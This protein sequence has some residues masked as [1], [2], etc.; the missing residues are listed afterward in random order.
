MG[1]H[2]GAHLVGRLAQRRVVPRERPRGHDLRTVVPHP[3]ELVPRIGRL[4][5]GGTAEH[6]GVVAA[7]RQDLHQ[8][9]AV[10][11]GIEVDRRGRLDA[12]LRAEVAPPGQNLAHEGL[13]RRHVAVR[14]QEPAPHDV[15]L[16]LAHQP[17]DP[18]EQRRL[19][20]LHPLVE[21]RLVVVEDEAVELLAQVGRRAEGGDRLGGAL[22]PLPQPDGIEMGLAHEMDDGLAHGGSSR[23]KWV[24]APRTYSLPTPGQGQAPAPWDPWNSQATGHW[25]QA[26]GHR[27]L[28]HA[29]ARRREGRGERGAAPKPRRGDASPRTPRTR[30]RGTGRPARAGRPVPRSGCRPL[31]RRC[32]GGDGAKRVFRMAHRQQATGNR[33]PATGY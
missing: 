18:R 30:L 21:D 19:V 23:R 4:G 17:L 24:R 7:L 9:P 2:M 13:A 32:G 29:K 11:E 5:R 28:P 8:A 26:T 25:L 14:L 1:L 6:V 12:E 16:A 22:L 33:Q 27:R 31:A 20:L 15:P 3:H 10:P